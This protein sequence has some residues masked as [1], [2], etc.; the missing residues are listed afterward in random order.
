MLQLE[1][2]K[3]KSNKKNA[4]FFAIPIITIFHKNKSWS[5][6]KVLR[7]EL[8]QILFFSDFVD[9]NNSCKFSV[10]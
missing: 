6:K 7:Y 4:K 2:K 3:I 5:K 1:I 10:T 9:F 8:D